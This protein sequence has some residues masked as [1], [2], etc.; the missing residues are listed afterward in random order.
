[1]NQG[2]FEYG[3]GSK[4]KERCR[5]EGQRIMCDAM[6]WCRSVKESSVN[7]VRRPMT[8][9]R[10]PDM[11]MAGSFFSCNLRTTRTVHDLLASRSY[12]SLESR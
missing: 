5:M 1:V 6:T 3:D 10:L 8:R 11:G 7:M 4:N 12:D 9:E 2:P